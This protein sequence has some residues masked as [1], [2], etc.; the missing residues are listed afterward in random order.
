MMT[1]L[2][3]HYRSYPMDSMYCDD[4]RSHYEMIRNAGEKESPEI[5]RIWEEAKFSCIVALISGGI[6]LGLWLGYA[7]KIF[8]WQ[9]YMPF[10]ISGSIA[11]AICS[12]LAT[13]T[14]GI[15]RVRKER[16]GQIWLCDALARDLIEAMVAVARVNPLAVAEIRRIQEHGNDGKVF[17]FQLDEQHATVISDVGLTLLCDGKDVDFPNDDF[18]IIRLPNSKRVI[19]IKCYG[20]RM[21]PQ[22]VLPAKIEKGIYR[23]G[24]PFEIDWDAFLAGKV[25][26]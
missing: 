23:D 21:I 17:V 14:S 1:D 10:M 18:E 3:I 6:P 13:F 12:F 9:R 22:K 19:D 2:I 8:Q 5:K 26:I 24:E 4:L 16:Q 20:K 15:K 25:K 11:V 7:P